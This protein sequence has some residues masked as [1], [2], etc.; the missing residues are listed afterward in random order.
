M[1]QLGFQTHITKHVNA[2]CKQ[3]SAVAGHSRT[4]P[5]PRICTTAACVFQGDWETGHCSGQQ[6]KFQ[7]QTSYKC[8]GNRLTQSVHDVPVFMSSAWNSSPGPGGW[9][10]LPDRVSAEASIALGISSCHSR[11][12]PLLTALP[13]ERPTNQSQSPTCGGAIYLLCTSDVGQQRSVLVTERLW[14]A[15]AQCAEPVTARLTP[16]TGTRSF[17]QSDPNASPVPAPQGTRD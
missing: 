9:T 16:F 4:T 15:H 17:H 14:S 7:A 2:T 1:T 10:A 6:D 11:A 12:A 8:V 13:S 5:S 3:N